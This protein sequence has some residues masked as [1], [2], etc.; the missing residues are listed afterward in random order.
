MRLTRDRACAFQIEEGSK[1]GKATGFVEGGD[2]DHVDLEELAALPNLRAHR[3]GGL[4]AG[5]AD[6]AG[7]G[8]ARPFM[9]T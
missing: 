6:G 9:S 5:R 1:R 4:A 2:V 8:V 3:H 7:A